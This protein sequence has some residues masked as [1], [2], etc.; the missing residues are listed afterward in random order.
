VKI[1]DKST[2][3]KAGETVICIIN[4]R[5]NL[6]IGKEYKVIQVYENLSTDI[7]RV[8]EKYKH[9]STLVIENDNGEPQWYDNMRFLPQSEF[10]QLIINDILKK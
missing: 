2:Q 8:W 10:R 1:K 4:S 6:T 9:E 7:S 5:A 3:F